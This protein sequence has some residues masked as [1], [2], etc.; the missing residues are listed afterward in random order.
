[1][2]SE[3]TIRH[4]RMD[5]AQEL[6]AVH[7]TCWEQAYSGILPDQ[8]WNE[9]ALQRRIDSW[10]QMLADP[11]HRA[12]T[13]VAEVDGEV[14][15]IAQIGPPREDDLDVEHELYMIYLLAE[16]HGC[17]AAEDMLTELLND[18]SASLWVLR[19][20]PRA[21]AFYRRYGFESDGVEKDLGDD[22]GAEALSGIVEIRMVR[23]SK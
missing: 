2:S 14:I 18:K 6:A 20:N 13:R 17:G 21:L 11:A 10:R 15:G 19:D 7:V 8:F 9:Q 1:M 22:R 12:R 23:G 5:E 3:Y 16:H 4:P